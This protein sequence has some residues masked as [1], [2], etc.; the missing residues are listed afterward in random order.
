MLVSTI[1]FFSP[2]FVLVVSR[3]DAC[4]DPRA[5]QENDEGCR[6]HTEVP[7]IEFITLT[8]CHHVWYKN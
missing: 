7:V 5:G 4:G 3:D 1:L 2:D 8:N 6:C